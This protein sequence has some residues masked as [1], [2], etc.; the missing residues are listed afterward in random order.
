MKWEGHAAN[1]AETRNANR[2]LVVKY[3]KDHLG[4]ISVVWSII[5]K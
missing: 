5:L 3:I 1:M 2:M 4:D